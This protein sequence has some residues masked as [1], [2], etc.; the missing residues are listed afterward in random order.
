MPLNCGL[1]I[2]ISMRN[3]TPAEVLATLAA[4]NAVLVDVRQPEELELAR[5]DAALHIP[6][7]EIPARLSELDAAK[8][9]AVLCHHG[10]RSLQVARFLERNGY[11]DVIN[12]AGGI[13]AWS[14]LDPSIPRY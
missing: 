14:D 13:D 11:A 7:A 9:V 5:V 8:T 12:V 4:G 10:G 3:Q 2:P 6:M 1:I